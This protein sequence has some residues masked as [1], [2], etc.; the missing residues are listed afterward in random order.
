MSFFLQYKKI[1]Y[2][3]SH[4]KS[5]NFKSYLNSSQGKGS[6][7]WNHRLKEKAFQKILT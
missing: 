7:E 1:I 4:Y 3:L 5:K 6:N 2:F